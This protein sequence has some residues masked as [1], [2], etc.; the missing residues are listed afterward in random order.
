MKETMKE[1]IKKHRIDIIIIAS[2]LLLSITVLLVTQITRKDGAA[3]TVTVNGETVGEYPLDRDGV[4]TI[5]GGTNIL[6]VEGGIAYMSYS[7][8]PDH[9]CE[10]TGKV[11][12]VGEQIVCLPNKVTVTVSGETLENGGVDFVS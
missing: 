1:T 7:D 8:C 12:Y 11:R 10:K 6:T 5:N 2:L 4:Y 3:V 9:V